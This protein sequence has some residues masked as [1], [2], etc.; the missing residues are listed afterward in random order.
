MECL[1]TETLTCGWTYTAQTLNIST[2][3]PLKFEIPQAI[4]NLAKPLS[5]KFRVAEYVDGEGKIMKVNLQVAV[6][7]HTN[8]GGGCYMKHDWKDVERVQLPFIG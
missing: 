6:Y 1:N 8:M 3:N 4:V 2:N 7:E 5:Y